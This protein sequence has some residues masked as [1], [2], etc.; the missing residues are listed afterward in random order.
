[1]DGLRVLVAHHRD[2]PVNPDLVARLVYVALLHLRRLH[3]A[4][5]ELSDV[6]ERGGQ[7]V[8]VRDGEEVR[9]K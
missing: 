5:E 7:V 8:R 3:L 4:L 6:R 2:A 9:Q 1:M